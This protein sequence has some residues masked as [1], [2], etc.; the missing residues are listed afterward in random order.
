[1]TKIAT[2]EEYIQRVD[3]YKNL[4]ECWRVDSNQSLEAEEV[5][6]AMEERLDYVRSYWRDIQ[7]WDARS[8][9]RIVHSD[10]LAKRTE[11]RGFCSPIK[12]DAILRFE[13]KIKETFG[14]KGVLVTNQWFSDSD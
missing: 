9:I 7:D 5:I 12:D 2:K 6:S 10:K 3:D 13:Q 1:M 14:S 11:R 4:M 8:K